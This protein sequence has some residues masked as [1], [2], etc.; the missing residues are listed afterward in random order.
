MALRIEHA[1][2]SEL[3]HAFIYGLKD[4]VQAEVRLHNPTTLTEAVHLALEFNELMEP[5][6]FEKGDR[7]NWRGN[8]APHHL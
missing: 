5:T 4:R 2:D 7:S 6:C 3:L 1:S 8:V